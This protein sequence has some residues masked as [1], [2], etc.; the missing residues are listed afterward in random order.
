MS[1]YDWGQTPGSER[2][3]KAVDEAR[4]TVISHPFIRAAGQDPARKESAARRRVKR[5]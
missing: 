4:R 1:R 3:E 5:E 2:L